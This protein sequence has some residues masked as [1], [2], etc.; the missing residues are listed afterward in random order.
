MPKEII[1]ATKQ[2]MKLQKGAFKEAEH[3]AQICGELRLLYMEFRPY[4]PIIIALKNP[5]FKSRHFDIIRK[6]KE[7][8][9]KIEYDLHE[10]IQDLVKQ[11]VMEIIDDITEVS[12]IATKERQLESQVQK[13]QSEWKTVRFTL[14]DYRDSG[15]VILTGV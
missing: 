10:S 2:C 14:E 5:D 6:L 1:D 9:F 12:E 11:G 7:P 15:S 3:T 8:A 4:L 13:M